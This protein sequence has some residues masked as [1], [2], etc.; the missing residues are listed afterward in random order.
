MSSC[1][2]MPDNLY[3]TCWRYIWNNI[4]NHGMYR[5]FNGEI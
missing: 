1:M 2:Y 3:N 5:L 4:Y